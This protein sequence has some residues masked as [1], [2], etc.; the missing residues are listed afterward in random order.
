MKVYIFFIL[1]FLLCFTQSKV[2][3]EELKI[4]ALYGVQDELVYD[5]LNLALSKVSSNVEI[6]ESLDSRSEA[7]IREEVQ[8]GNLDLMWGGASPT[9]ESKML[10]VRIPILKGLLGHRIF[11]IRKGEQYKFDNV[12][13]IS[14]LKK[15]YAGQGTFWGDTDILKKAGIPVYT[16]IK[17]PN[18]FLMIDGERFDYFPRAINEPW[19]EVSSRKEMNLAVEKKLMLVYPYA[20][21]FF[22]KKNN[23][24]LHDKI[25]K[26]F[27]MAIQDGSFD[28]LFFNSPII[29]NMF[30]K[31]NIEQRRVLKIENPY[32]HPN[33]PLEREEFWLDLN[34]VK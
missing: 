25:Y 7:R 30:K 10:T 8:A 34:N 29:N 14:D 1:L 28:E 19:D 11:I 17:Y 6:S 4:R 3:A 12:H 33:T 31:I 26:G 32:M 22:V 15:L 5:I 24:Y 2:F 23:K 9:N 18:L 27:E 21:Y 20:M 16:S 13:T